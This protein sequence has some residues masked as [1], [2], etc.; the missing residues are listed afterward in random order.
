MPIEVHPTLPII[1]MNGS[2]PAHLLQ[3]YEAG[4]RSLDEA[5]TAFHKIDIH[6]R[7]YYPRGDDAWPKANAERTAHLTGLATALAYLNAVADHIRDQ[8]EEREASHRPSLYDA[9]R[10]NDPN[11]P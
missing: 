9:L 7:D 1:H 8:I 11:N 10:T 2:S 3:E 6:P 5:L 4:I